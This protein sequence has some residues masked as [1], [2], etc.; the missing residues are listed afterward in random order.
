M[1]PPGNV[2]ADAHGHRV[3]H[4]GELQ[5]SPLSLLCVLMW[6]LPNHNGEKH[7]LEVVLH[8]PV[9][10][11]R[12][13]CCYEPRTLNRRFCWCFLFAFSFSLLLLSHQFDPTANTETMP[14][15]EHCK[16]SILKSSKFDFLAFLT[17]S[18]EDTAHKANGTVKHKPSPVYNKKTTALQI[19]VSHTTH[20]RCG[21][22]RCECTST[23]RRLCP[24]IQAR[25]RTPQHRHILNKQISCTLW[26]YS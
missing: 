5:K 3:Y 18:S 11:T 15:F 8:I 7:G 19:I 4:S 6:R 10:T 2:L 20:R 1:L 13:R 23:A 21:L 14:C 22:S 25:L 9:V 26:K 17:P 12:D 16:S 24:P